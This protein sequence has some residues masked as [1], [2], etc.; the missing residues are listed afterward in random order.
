MS[1]PQAIE[2][3]PVSHRGVTSPKLVARRNRRPP[4]DLDDF[5]LGPGTPTIPSCCVSTSVGAVAPPSN[6]HHSATATSPATAT[7][8]DP[9][10]TQQSP[11]PR[12]SKP[13]ARRHSMDAG[14][15]AAAP[16][17][18]SAPHPS[19]PA[20]APV[21][22]WEGSAPPNLDSEGA[23]C[24]PAGAPRSEL[25]ESFAGLLEWQVASMHALVAP[26]LSA[27][28]D[29]APAQLLGLLSAASAAGNPAILAATA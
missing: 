12:P 8:L 2:A 29:S 19:T 23:L 4:A 3:H 7:E 26:L 16:R 13:M 20:A 17:R 25:Q 21:E 18:P 14:H 10:E 5:T 1:S 22:T 11:A 28:A 27:G 6:Q 9:G 15:P 24:L